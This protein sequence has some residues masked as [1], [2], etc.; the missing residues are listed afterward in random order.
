MGGQSLVY[1]DESEGVIVVLLVVSQCW[2]ELVIAGRIDVRRLAG[3]SGL[4]GS[5][6][7][8]WLYGSVFDS[9]SCMELDGNAEVLT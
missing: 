6:L 8:A 3:R 9:G 2:H 7:L 1:G 5:L 4:R